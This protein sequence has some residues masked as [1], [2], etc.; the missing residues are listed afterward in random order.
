MIQYQR[1]FGGGSLAGERLPGEVIGWRDSA[2]PR[3]LSGRHL[4]ADT[5]RAGRLPWRIRGDPPGR[6]PLAALPED[7]EMVLL[8]RRL[9]LD[10]M[11]LVRLLDWF[12][13]QRPGGRS[14]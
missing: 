10:Q 13:A 5:G 6:R 12:G 3:A 14:S 11:I 2:A 1:R 7:E 4:F 9:P 8:V